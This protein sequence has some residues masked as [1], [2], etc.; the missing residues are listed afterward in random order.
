[1]VHTIKVL[2]HCKRFSVSLKYISE[3][4][5][6]LAIP[7]IWMW[8]REEVVVV[9]DSEQLMSSEVRESS[10]LMGKDTNGST[11]FDLGGANSQHSPKWPGTVLFS[12]L[13][14]IKMVWIC[15]ITFTE[16]I[17]VTFISFLPLLL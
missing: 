4:L 11:E 2:L 17:F 3:W 7:K 9:F 16:P 13:Y 14:V 10:N 6:L 12:S 1:M 5:K 8:E 15:H